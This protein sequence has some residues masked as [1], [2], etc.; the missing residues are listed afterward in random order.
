MLSAPDEAQVRIA[1]RV[2]YRPSSYKRALLDVAPGGVLRV[3]SVGGDF[4]L[5][6][7]ADEPLLLVAGGIGITPFVA[8]LSSAA[9]DRDVV[10]VYA[11]PASADLAF[12][13]EVAAFPGVVVTADEPAELP[14]GWRWVRGAAVTEQVLAAAAPDLAGAGCT[15]PV[16]RRWSPRYAG[17]PAGWA[18]VPCVPTPSPGTDSD[19]ARPCGCELPHSCATQGPADAVALSDTETLP[20]LPAGALNERD[21]DGFTNPTEPTTATVE[22]HSRTCTC[23]DRRRP[24]RRGR[25]RRSPAGLDRRRAGRR[26]RHRSAR[27]DLDRATPVPH[28]A[29]V[30]AADD[31]TRCPASSCP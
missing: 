10:L 27:A 2:P 19:P 21:T 26:R 25:D 30:R 3:N 9:A 22:T 28:A 23:V 7:A 24:G 12:L 11:A 4:L 17:R 18:P 8:Q 15:C 1:T 20:E 16:R 31:D 14:A 5:P 13:D 6:K 29:A